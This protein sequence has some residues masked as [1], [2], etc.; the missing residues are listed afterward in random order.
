MEIPSDKR[1]MTLHDIQQVCLRIV[2]RLHDFCQQHGITYTLTGGTLVGVIRHKGFVPWDDDIDILMRRPDYERFCDLFEDTEEFK[3]FAPKRHNTRIPYARLCE[4]RDTLVIPYS[5]CFEGDSGVWIDIFPVDAADEDFDTY[6]QRHLQLKKVKHLL[7]I[8]RMTYVPLKREKTLK[9]KLYILWH[10]VRATRKSCAQLIA[11]M[12]RIS[13]SPVE[14]PTHL[15]NYYTLYPKKEHFPQE[16][17][18]STIEGEFEGHTFRIMSGYDD[19]LRRLF[20]DY[21]QL[22]PEEQ[23]HAKHSRHVYCWKS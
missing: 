11:E 19:F 1:E 8:K 21:M 17:F 13:T 23:R 9:E 20:G 22:P 7:D 2:L 12:E 10:R 14:R 3:L 5:P 15:T 16:D 18:S 6:F 4:M